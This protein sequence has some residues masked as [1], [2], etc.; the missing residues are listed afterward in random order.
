[1]NSFTYFLHGGP[2]GEPKTLREQQDDIAH[3]LT[4]ERQTEPGTCDLY[5]LKSRSETFRTARYEWHT[6]GTPEAV[7]QEMAELGK[8][9]MQS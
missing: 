5:V 2:A 9:M 4:I 6:G 1:M 8:A 3:V 7:M